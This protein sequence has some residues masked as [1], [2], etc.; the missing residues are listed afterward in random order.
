[1]EAM[2]FF[3]IGCFFR[4]LHSMFSISAS[5]QA[6]SVRSVEAC[7]LAYD[8]CRKEL[9]REIPKS[10]KTLAFGELFFPGSYY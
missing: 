2:F 7:S 10:S 3:I 9:G 1:M 5:L 4:L 6:K 8:K